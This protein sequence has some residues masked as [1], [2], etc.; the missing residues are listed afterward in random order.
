MKR[1]DLNAKLR[2]YARSQVS[3]TQAERDLVSKLYSSIRETLGA[4]CYLIGSYARFTASRPMHDVDVLFVAGD[5]NP[6]Q[7]A[8]QPI[9]LWLHRKLS[10]EFKNPTPY[11]IE[12]SQQ[13][14][15]VTVCFMDN[16]TEKFAIDVVPAFRSGAKNEFGDDIFWVPEILR[17]SR[18]NRRAQYEALEKRNKSELEWWI[19]SDPRGYISE[20]T[21]L[22]AACSDYQKITKLVKRWKHNCKKRNGELELKSFHVEQLIIRI[23]KKNP[24]AEISAILFDFLCQLPDAMNQPQI[25]DRADASKFIDEYVRGLTP[26]QKQIIQQARDSFLIELENITPQT[27]V[28]SVVQGGLH[29]RNGHAE[30]YLFDQRI[31]VLVDPSVRLKIRAKV[32]PKDG[33]RSGELDAAGIINVDRK[34]N[35]TCETSAPYTIDLFKWK[36]KNDNA[37]PQPRGEITDHG[38]PNDPERTRYRGD[39]NV[40]CFAIK[41]GTCVGRTKQNVVI[42]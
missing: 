16:Q 5:F 13:T 23:I 9:L 29:S 2:D 10:R 37:S 7:I 19:K 34:I 35:F 27:D 12:I 42:K 6:K 39:H 25:T 31:P 14:H 30:S 33:F 1:D 36:V 41:G 4:S 18:R 32:Q 11:R 3:P 26:Q 15:S 24:N 38:T 40:E 20:S 28:G 22:N 21:R 8:P 17:V